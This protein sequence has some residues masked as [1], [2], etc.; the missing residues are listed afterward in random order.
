MLF[1]TGAVLC[2]SDD[3]RFN[4]NIF[5]NLKLFVNLRLGGLRL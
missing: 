1:L 4:E 3:P 2:L 5:M